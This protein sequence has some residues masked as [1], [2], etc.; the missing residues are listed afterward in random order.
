M[1]INI[2]FYTDSG[3]KNIRKFVQKEGWTIQDIST[4]G[5]GYNWKINLTDK[6]VNI[7]DTFEDQEFYYYEDS[8]EALEHVL[9]NNIR[10]N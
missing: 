7:V 8:P 10:L 2:R 1:N 4:D 6:I 5:I 9:L 3:I